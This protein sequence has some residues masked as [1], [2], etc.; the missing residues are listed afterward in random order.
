MRNKESSVVL[1]WVTGWKTDL[2]KLSTKLPGHKWIWHV[3]LEISFRDTCKCPLNLSKFCF[4]TS[5][6][7]LRNIYKRFPYTAQSMLNIFSIIVI[8]EGIMVFFSH[9]YKNCTWN[10][11]HYFAC[12]FSC[13]WLKLFYFLI[14]GFVKY[15]VQ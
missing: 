9:R 8:I 5:Q 10:L 14:V 11:Q 3:F 7:F 12:V 13:L 1:S 15:I 6:L 4:I 2:Q